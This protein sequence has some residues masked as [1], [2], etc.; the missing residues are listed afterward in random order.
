MTQCQACFR[1]GFDTTGRRGVDRH[2][3]KWM[4]I[5]RDRD[6]GALLRD[7]SNDAMKH[8]WKMMRRDEEATQRLGSKAAETS[9][10]AGV[11]SARS[12]QGV[13]PARAQAS[14]HASGALTSSLSPLRGSSAAG[15]ASAGVGGGGYRAPA[16]RLSTGSHLGGGARGLPN[17]GLGANGKYSPLLTSAIEEVRAAAARTPPPTQARAS[18][19]HA[20]I[21][22]LVNVV[23]VCKGG[24][25]ADQALPRGLLKTLM[26]FLDPFCSIVTLQ[27]R[28]SD[29]SNGK[30]GADQGA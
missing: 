21:A 13:L 12:S 3:R 30:P 1:T 25:Q 6:F 17:G 8:K 20:I 11:A 29:I 14:A 7:F 24:V 15:G 23:H 4:T 18:L 16:E 26:E 22:K 2:G 5:K 19:P 27:K 28:M 10:G 9:S